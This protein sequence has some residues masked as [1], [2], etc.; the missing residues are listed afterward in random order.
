MKAA[1]ATTTDEIDA[2][3]GDART[4]R[5]TEN[6]GPRRSG[7]VRV[8]WVPSAISIPAAA[9]VRRPSVSASAL[10]VPRMARA[11]SRPLKFLQRASHYRRALD[12]DAL[13]GEHVGSE[14]RPPARNVSAYRARL[15]K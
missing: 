14:S 6:A 11:R 5:D 13:F 3:S 8:V 9:D 12:A 1:A 2:G 4:I 10:F 7:S 15:D